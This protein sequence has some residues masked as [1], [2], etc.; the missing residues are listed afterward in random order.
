MRPLTLV[1]CGAPLASRA[2]EVVEVLSERWSVSVVVSDAASAWFSV[3]TD[4]DRPR[5]ERVV[6]CPLTFNTANKVVA[7]VMDTAACGV[8]CDAMG[9]GVGIV[10]VPMVNDRLWAHPTWSRTLTALA[11]S[12]VALVDLASGRIG[13]PRAVV[14][15]NGDAAVAGFDPRWVADTFV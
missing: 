13:E 1:V 15:G 2:G 14:S 5:P 12:D 11:G 7:G 9:A 10:A 4:V 3:A 8:V 6:V